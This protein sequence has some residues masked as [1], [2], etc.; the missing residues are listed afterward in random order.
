MLFLNVDN[1][2]L[3][4]FIIQQI[5]YHFDKR[6]NPIMTNATGVTAVLLKL[7]LTTILI[8]AFQKNIF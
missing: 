5:G 8:S 7:M 2:D 6:K 3:Y 1:C 4:I